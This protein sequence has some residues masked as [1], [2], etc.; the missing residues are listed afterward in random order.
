M[1]KINTDTFEVDS[2]KLQL[3]LSDV[4]VINTSGLQQNVI[5]EKIIEASGLIIDTATETKNKHIVKINGITTNYEVKSYFNQ[6]TLKTEIKI[7]IGLNSKQL[8]SQYFEGLTSETIKQV[9]DYIISQN[10]LYVDYDVFINSN[11]VDVDFKY[12]TY[13]VEQDFPKMLERVKKATI[14][15][16]SAGHGI[17]DYNKK[18]NQGFQFSTRK[19][20]TYSNPFIKFY[21]KHRQIKSYAKSGMLDFFNEYLEADFSNQIE[22]LFR[23]EYTL[24][25]KLMFDKFGA[26][27]NTLKDILKIPNDVK[28]NIAKDIFAK[29]TERNKKIDRN[30]IIKLSFAEKL[31]LLY[32]VEA[33]EN[34]KSLMN[35]KQDIMNMNFRSE[36]TKKLFENLENLDFENIDTALNEKILENSKI[37]VLLNAIGM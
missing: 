31:L 7:N 11:C 24:K 16:I 36:Q 22:N 12:D 9:Y 17:S 14:P 13:F 37:D 28:K 15:K 1:K 27:A 19:T 23:V 2:L 34:G 20:A 5:T 32:K 35:M 21:N 4:E 3:K 10:V 29:H 8:K 33:V 18:H 30:K 26:G 6:S 25:D